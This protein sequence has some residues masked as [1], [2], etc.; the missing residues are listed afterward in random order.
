M[1][2]TD[3]LIVTQFTDYVVPEAMVFRIFQDMRGAQATYR[4]T[5]NTTTTLIHSVAQTDDVINVANAAALPAPN[6]P[7]N[8]WGVVT[9]DAERIMYRTRDTVN[10]TISGL[11][12]GTAGT[13]NAPHDAGAE[14][15]SMGLGNLLYSEYQNYVVS[16][17]ILANG[18]ETLFTAPSIIIE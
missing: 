18:T 1:Q 11:L 12:R 10:N 17:T 7:D 6:L 8:V 3:Q 15:Y 5:D 4:I 13:A 2:P 14:V 16:D 9:I